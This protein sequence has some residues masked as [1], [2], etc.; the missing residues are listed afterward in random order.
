[1]KISRF[2]L[3]WLFV[4]AN[5]ACA[6]RQLAYRVLEPS[7]ADPSE[8]ILTV[9]LVC[10]V[11]GREYFTR[12]VCE[13]IERH[14][15]MRFVL[16]DEMNPDGVAMALANDTCWRGNANQ[17]DLNRNFPHRLAGFRMAPQ[18]KREEEYPGPHSFSEWETRFVDRLLLKYMPNVLLSI[19]SG[20][21]SVMIPYDGSSSD[22]YPAYERHKRVA[23]EALKDKCNQCKIGK[24]S[25]MAGYTAI[26]TLSDYASLIMQVPWVYTLEIFLNASSTRCEYQFNPPNDGISQQHVASLWSNQFIPALLDRIYWEDIDKQRAQFLQRM[27]IE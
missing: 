26:G 3:L 9:M 21:I 12:Q 15:K 1:M 8:R 22:V 6:E 7:L 19:H 25:I 11:H 20:E 14:D 27:L 2:A 10:A 4:F 23:Q 16:V 17:V 13:R 18:M 5:A 24:A